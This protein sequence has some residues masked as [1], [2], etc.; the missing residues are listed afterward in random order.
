MTQAPLKERK[1]EYHNLF[2]RNNQSILHTR[3][4]L[5]EMVGFIDVPRLNFRRVF[6]YTFTP[7][8]TPARCRRAMAAKSCSE[9][10]SERA[11]TRTFARRAAIT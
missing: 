8:V 7:G 5:S 2:C 3:N 9:F 1:K 11:P 10:Q 6:P 4:D